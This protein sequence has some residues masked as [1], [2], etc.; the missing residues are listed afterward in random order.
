MSHGRRT[1]DFQL[2]PPAQS[3]SRERPVSARLARYGLAH[4][5]AQDQKPRLL[6][7]RGERRAV[8]QGAACAFGALAVQ[9]KRLVPPPGG[10]SRPGAAAPGNCPAANRV[11]WIAAGALA[12]N[13]DM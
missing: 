12:G 8:Q 9:I 11:A 10:G 7:E 4:P 13:R 3:R 1:T 6:A 2:D 5:M